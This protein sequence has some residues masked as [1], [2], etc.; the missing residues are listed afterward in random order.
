MEDG[1]E[2]GE[3][4][5]D[6]GDIVIH[7]DEGR[8]IPPS[9]LAQQM[10]LV[11]KQPYGD[12]H[13]LRITAHNQD[14][15]R[16]PT[17]LRELPRNNI[18][19]SFNNKR[20]RRRLRRRKRTTLNIADNQNV[21]LHHPDQQRVHVHQT[22]GG[23][24]Y[25]KTL[26]V[27]S[28][29]SI[30]NQNSSIQQHQSSGDHQNTHVQSQGSNQDVPRRQH[31]P[32]S[33]DPQTH[34]AGLHWLSFEPAPPLAAALLPRQNSPQERLNNTTHSPQEGLNN[35]THSPQAPLDNATH[36]LCILYVEKFIN[37]LMKKFV[38]YRVLITKWQLCCNLM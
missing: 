29:R 17:Q 7:L 38:S 30:Y 3:L 19:P 2:E 32:S 9:S 20:G 26:A 15:E 1:K 13:S 31:R 35:T 4:T 28:Q 6:E 18:H 8:S 36:C 10:D 16:C 23:G 21:L 11:I 5:D 37:K 33:A 34:T 14:S 22:F 24:G 12:R 25:Q 27:L